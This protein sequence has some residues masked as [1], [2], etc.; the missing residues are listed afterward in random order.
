MP[1]TLSRALVHP[2]IPRRGRPQPRPVVARQRVALAR[3]LLEAS[4]LPVDLVASR[5]GVGTGASLRQ[6]L[7][8]AIGVSPT[9]YRRT[10][11]GA[12]PTAQGRLVPSG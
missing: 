6:H 8:A 12:G 4:D 11:A 3:H 7:H 2:P 5:A 1:N 10:F 9:A